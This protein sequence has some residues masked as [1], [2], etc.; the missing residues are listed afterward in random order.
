MDQLLRRLHY[1]GLFLLALFVALLQPL[2]SFG[3][4]VYGDGLFGV[5]GI[6]VKEEGEVFFIFDQISNFTLVRATNEGEPLAAKPLGGINV[7]EYAGTRISF[8]PV[9]SRLLLLTPQ[10]VIHLV[11]PDTLES[12]V[13]LDLRGLPH[14][15]DAAFNIVNGQ[16]EPF[17]TGISPTY[18]DIAV[19][20]RDSSNA[21]IFVTGNTGASGGFNFVQRLR[22]DYRHK[23]L[24]VKLVV[25]SSSSSV[26][27]GTN[28]IPGIAVNQFGTVLTTLPLE[29]KPG[30]GSEIAVAFSVDFPEAQTLGTVP[31]LLFPTVNGFYRDLW[32]VGMTSDERGN[33]YVASGPVGSSSCGAFGSGAVVVIPKTLDSLEC[34]HFGAHLSRSKDVAIDPLKNQLYVTFSSPTGTILRLPLENAPAPATISSEQGNDATVVPA[35]TEVIGIRAALKDVVEAL[36]LLGSKRNK[37]TERALVRSLKT[38]KSLISNNEA[39]AESLSVNLKRKSVIRALSR[40]RKLRKTMGVKRKR[41]LQKLK[42]SVALLTNS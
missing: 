39:L 10:G 22:I 36:D 35:N 25:F 2:T 33:F 38:L 4:E 32:S 7:S 23:T 14:Q 42:R 9:L 31:R 13:F 5:N 28:T 34:Y 40:A 21:D 29:S 27:L 41:T 15:F 17:F 24:G 18:S 6:H 16:F 19:Y 3:Q 1:R 26:S 11:Q 37:K 8:D 30:I 20:Q 12:L